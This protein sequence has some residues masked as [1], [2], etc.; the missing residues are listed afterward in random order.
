MKRIFF[1]FLHEEFVPE[2]LKGKVVLVNPGF[3]IAK[4]EVNYE[5]PE[6]FPL[7]NLTCE[8]YMKDLSIYTGYFKDPLEI[9]GNFFMNLLQQQEEIPSKIK[10][11]I[12]K[13][14]EVKSSINNYL[15]AQITFL[16]L[17]FLEE[18]VLELNKIDEDVHKGMQKLHDILGEEEILNDKSFTSKANSVNTIFQTLPL[19]KILPYFFLIIDNEKH[20]LVTTKREL[21]DMWVDFGIEFKNINGDEFISSDYGYKY[22]LKKRS[23]SNMEWLNKKY[24]VTY[25]GV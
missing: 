22:L 21:F 11:E 8:K 16:L 17:W 20:M 6:K 18:K 24:N 23:I 12:K 4:S 13:G 3:N 1:P 19:E 9:Q 5:R 10:S 14:E 15:K 2:V 25:I 7:D